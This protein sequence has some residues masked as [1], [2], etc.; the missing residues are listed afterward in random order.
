MMPLLFNSDIFQRHIFSPSCDC[1]FLIAIDK[2]IE[3]KK[4]R[5]IQIL[6]LVLKMIDLCF[7]C[8][9]I[10]IS[11]KSYRYECLFS[12]F[13]TYCVHKKFYLAHVSHKEQQKSFP[14]NITT[15]IEKENGCKIIHTTSFM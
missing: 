7:S 4:Q 11:N 9:K 6:Y 12:S 1:I 15:Q 8:L 10:L 3:G 13:Y 5:V 14:V 2:F